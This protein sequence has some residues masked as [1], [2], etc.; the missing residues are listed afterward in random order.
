MTQLR[1]QRCS[2][3]GR[4]LQGGGGTPVVT[5]VVKPG[6]QVRTSPGVKDGSEV[7]VGWDAGGRTGCTSLGVLLEEADSL[8]VGPSVS[9]FEVP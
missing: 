9:L 5:P 2:L 3:L 8:E 6:L 7:E 1:L 4:E